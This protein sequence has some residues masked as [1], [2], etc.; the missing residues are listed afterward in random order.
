MQGILNSRIK[1]DKFCIKNKI[2]IRSVS[3]ES[4][5]DL[6]LQSPNQCLEKYEGFSFFNGLPN[7][8]LSIQQIT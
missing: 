7:E 3:T 8:K 6:L 4:S 2:C 1:K 5:F